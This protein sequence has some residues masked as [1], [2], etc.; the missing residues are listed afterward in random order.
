MLSWSL[1]VRRLPDA[2]HRPSAKRK[3]LA[4]SCLP[5]CL[6]TSGVE[7]QDRKSGTSYHCY[8][9]VYPTWMTHCKQFPVGDGKIAHWSTDPCVCCTEEAGKSRHQLVPRWVLL[10][11]L[12]F[13][14]MNH[15]T[16]YFNSFIFIRAH[17]LHKILLFYNL[18]NILRTM[19][20]NLR[21]IFRTILWKLA[22]AR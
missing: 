14:C 7:P 20:F 19:L 22:I 13:N 9:R 17:R 5:P 11:T 4:F 1:T 6:Q 16:F 21:A 8:S 18:I 2:L 12:S 15:D 3:F 10:R